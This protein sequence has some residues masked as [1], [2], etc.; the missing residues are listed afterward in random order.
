MTQIR[1]A[2]LIFFLITLSFLLNSAR[3][4]AQ[5]GPESGSPELDDSIEVEEVFVTGSLIP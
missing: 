3:A 4:I 2:L 5:D 1:Q